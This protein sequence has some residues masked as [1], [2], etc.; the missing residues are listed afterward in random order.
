MYGDDPDFFESV[1]L[2]AWVIYHAGNLLM[3]VEPCHR[4]CQQV[5]RTKHLISQLL[6]FSPAEHYSLM[7][8]LELFYKY[9]M[10]SEIVYTP[11]NMFNLNRSIIAA[12][13]GSITTYIVVIIQI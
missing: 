13:L 7:S 10:S 11:L 8:E 12:I 3:I 1:I 4:T 9:L 5:T 6:R 2:V